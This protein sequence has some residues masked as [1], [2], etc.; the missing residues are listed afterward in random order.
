LQS[1]CDSVAEARLLFQLH[2]AEHPAYADL[3]DS[4]R[5]RFVDNL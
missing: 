1:N 4:Q 3:D 2:M 5:Q